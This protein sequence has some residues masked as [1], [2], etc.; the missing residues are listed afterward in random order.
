M[1]EVE[2]VAEGVAVVVEGPDFF[3]GW[4]AFD[5]LTMEWKGTGYDTRVSLDALFCVSYSA[6]FQMAIQDGQ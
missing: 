6:F 2:D 3:E 4:L 1:E 5:D